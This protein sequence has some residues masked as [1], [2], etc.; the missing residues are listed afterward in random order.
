[1]MRLGAPALFDGSGTAPSEKDRGFESVSLQR[2]VYC[3]PD[4]RRRIP[5]HKSRGI[6][7]LIA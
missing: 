7:L 6:R 1:M 2:R 4:F 3:E 5:S